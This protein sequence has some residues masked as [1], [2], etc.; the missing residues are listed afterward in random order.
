[1]SSVVSLLPRGLA[2][3]ALTVGVVLL[4]LPLSVPGRAAA[5]D[6]TVQGYVYRDLDDD[7]VRDVDEPGLRGVVLRSGSRSAITDAAGHYAFAGVT[8]S[9]NIR[10]DAGWFRTQCTSA[11]SGPSRGD[12][13]TATCPDPGAGA[14]VDQDFRVD[15]QLLTAT[16]APGDD[17][18]LGLTPDWVGTG[19]TAYTTDPLASM[20]LDPALRLSPGYRMPG[21][22]VDCQN[23]ICRPGETQWDLTQWLNQGTKPLRGLRA[24]VVAPAGSMIT[25]VT[26]YV[27]H[28]PGSGH[29]VTGYVVKDAATGTT[30][31]VGTDGWLSS[32]SPR[33]KVNLKGRLLPGSEYLTAV[34]YRMNDDAPFSDGNGD[35]LADCSA[36]TGTAYPGQTCTLATD[37]SPGSYVTWGAVIRIRRGVDADAVFCPTIPNDCPELGVHNKTRPGDSNDAGA[38]KVD[39]VYPPG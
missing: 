19:Y 1:M 7:G 21:A 5:V 16:A 12:A 35:G 27:G 37:F 10:A 24:V 3:S 32:P 22:A 13:Y 38:W 30:L 39:S 31:E 34:G 18:S 17:I 2:R 33:I 29:S 8:Q 25:Q 4:V 36:D 9:I 15:N 14:G 23:F 6:D 20:A 11:F 28:G 26:P